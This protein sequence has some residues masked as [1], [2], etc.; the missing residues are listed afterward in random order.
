MRVAAVQM[1][2]ASASFA[3]Q[4]VTNQTRPN[5]VIILGDDLGWGDLS[6]YGQKKFATPNLDRLATE[7]MRFTQFY[8][9]SPSGAASRGTLFT[10]K[11][12]GHA[13]IRGNYGPDG[14][15]VALRGEDA[16]DEIHRQWAL[17]LAERER[18]AV[19]VEVGISKSSSIVQLLWAQSSQDAVQL[20]LGIS[21]CTLDVHLV[22]RRHP[23]HC[24]HGRSPSSPVFRAYVIRRRPRRRPGPPGCR[25]R[26]C[27]R[28][29]ARL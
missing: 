28:V 21:R 25:G 10:G 23:R 15:P 3:Q 24:P 20:P 22:V 19:A 6:C 18:D 9:G 4:P 12:T 17:P 26:A 27:R 29:R 13:R 14:H 5:I 11:H 16:R 7:G 2:F 1:K 8:A